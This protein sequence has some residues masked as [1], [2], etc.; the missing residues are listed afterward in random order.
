M[1]PLYLIVTLLV[2]A[3]GVGWAQANAKNNRTVILVSVDGLAI[4][5]NYDDDSGGSRNVNDVYRW[6]TET[7]N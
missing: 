5:L 6:I 2:A 1:K 4:D 7:A 3:C